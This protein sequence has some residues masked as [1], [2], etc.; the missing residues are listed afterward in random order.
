MK[1]KVSVQ[2]GAAILAFPTVVPSDRD[3]T[4]TVKKN[5]V[6]IADVFFE[7]GSANTVQQATQVASALERAGVECVQK[8]GELL[9]LH[10]GELEIESDGD[11]VFLP[12][13]QE[14]EVSV[15]TTQNVVSAAVMAAL[16]TATVGKIVGGK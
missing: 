5:G 1:K 4:I 11:Y 6:N 15:D 9:I 3:K 7:A 14:L 2:V 13:V 12:L 10:T 8:S 16:A